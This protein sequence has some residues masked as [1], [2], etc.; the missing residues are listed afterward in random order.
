MV[1]HLAAVTGKAPVQEYFTTNVAGTKFLL[2]QC[3][4]WGVSR[5]LYMSSIAVTYPHVA[6]YYYAQSKQQA[7]EVVRNSGLSYTILRPTI[8]LGK[9]APAWKNLSHLARGPFIPLCGDGQTKIQP[10]D[11]NDLADVVWALTGE[12]IFPDDTFDIGGPEIITI[13][14]FLRQI[15]Q[16]CYGS[17]ARVI[18]IPFGLLASL[19][20]YAEKFFYS[21]IP[22]SLGQFSVFLYDSTVENNWVFERYKEKM[23]NINQMLR[24]I[25]NHE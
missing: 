1:I 4:R 13:E 17:T 25:K 2:E 21:L 16:V 15:A 6:R 18:H 19:L 10:I 11:V 24:N 7:E 9:D 20:T 5:F 8:V 12:G 3:Q 22:F 23:Q 14:K